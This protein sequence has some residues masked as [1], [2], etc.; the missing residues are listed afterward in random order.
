MTSFTQSGPVRTPIKSIPIAL[1]LSQL[2][3][4]LPEDLQLQDPKGAD[5]SYETEEAVP[6]KFF[7]VAS[8]EC[9]CN[10]GSWLRQCPRLWDHL[11]SAL[12]STS[13]IF[14]CPD[15]VHNDVVPRDCPAAAAHL[16]GMVSYH[17]QSR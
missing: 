2:A 11:Q 6:H 7:R 3:L 4:D 5:S 14:T 1:T 10:E 9:V 15:E 17:L 12:A 13:A 8:Q 16:V